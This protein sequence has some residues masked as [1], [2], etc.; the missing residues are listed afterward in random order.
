MLNGEPPL[1]CDTVAQ[2]QPNAAWLAIFSLAF[3]IF[4]LVTAELLPVSI[5]TPMA[6]DLGASTGA[7]GQAVTTTGL[8]A[9]ISGPIVV[10]GMGTID[11]RTIIIGL[12]LLMVGS[13][14]LAATATSVAVLL[15]ARAMLGVALGGSYGLTTAVALR[16]VPSAQVPRAIS[17]VAMGVSLAI[18]LATPL[19]VAIGEILGWRATFFA[20]ACVGAVAV[21]I[22]LL[23]L[24]R[25][26]ASGG[27]DAAAFLTALSRRGVQVG[28]V[29]AIIIISGHFAGFTFIRPFLETVPRLSFESLSLALF[30]FGIAGIAGNMAAGV[31]AARS[32]ASA[33]AGS[34]LLITLAATMLLLFG[35]STGG[36]FAATALWGFAFGG[37]PVAASIWNARIASDIAEPAG[38]LLASA[39]QIAI[40]GGALA[41]GFL[42]DTVGPEGPIALASAA[43]LIGGAFMV[44]NGR[45]IETSQ[46][47]K[48]NAL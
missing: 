28:I 11:R 16:I 4:G 42:I 1:A 21:L 34:A 37:V 2:Q 44:V 27:T 38:A 33:F 25:L 12:M 13:C 23:A 39:F 47:H 19:A 30:A 31:M 7:V 8:V 5:L 17:M 20:V 22:Q 3:G 45:A 24:P 10:A 9:A 18:V 26:P 41:G 48:D 14:I 29:A 35:R 6:N 32:P 46:P 40:A 43:T 15:L 36:A